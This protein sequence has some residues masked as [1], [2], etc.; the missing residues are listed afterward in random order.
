VIEPRCVQAEL[1]LFDLVQAVSESAANEAEVIA[2]VAHLLS[3]GRVKLAG[4]SRGKRVV[5]Q[6]V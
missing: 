2:T 5:V 1:T 4:E 3:S 6:Q